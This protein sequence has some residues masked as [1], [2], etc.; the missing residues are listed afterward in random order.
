M[1]TMDDLWTVER[2]CRW[3]YG[4]ADGEK[5]THSMFNSVERM[6]KNGILPAAKVGMCW[7][8]DTTEILKEFKR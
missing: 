5:P 7:R 1:T 6:C 4:L 8:I 2:F 3:K